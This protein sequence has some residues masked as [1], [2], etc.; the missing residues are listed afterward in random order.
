RHAAVGRQFPVS[1]ERPAQ[2]VEVTTG[3]EPPVTHERT[4]VGCW[5][6]VRVE[7]V[8]QDSRR[9]PDRASRF[10]D[11]HVL[12][13]HRWH[14]SSSWPVT[15]NNATRPKKYPPGVAGR[16]SLRCSLPLSIV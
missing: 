8:G 15:V 11:R 3:D 5:D 7:Q 1:P 12:C 14:L 13:R 6:T 16:S 4:L 2:H 10:P 9:C